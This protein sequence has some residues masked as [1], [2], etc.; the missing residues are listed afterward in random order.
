MRDLVC[1]SMRSLPLQRKELCGGACTFGFD[2]IDCLFRSN[3]GFSG[4]SCVGTG[5][6]AVDGGIVLLKMSAIRRSALSWAWPTSAKG[7]L[8][9]GCFNAVIKSSAASIAALTNEVVGIE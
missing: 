5:A 9:C 4:F 6:G 2:T 1:G 3:E 8:G 7:V